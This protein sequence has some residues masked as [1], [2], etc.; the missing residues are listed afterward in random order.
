MVYNSF[1]HSVKSGKVENTISFFSL[2]FCYLFERERAGKGEEEEDN[3]K[4]TPHGA[5]SPTQVSIP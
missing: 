4:L 5:Q 3:L 1:H 2:D